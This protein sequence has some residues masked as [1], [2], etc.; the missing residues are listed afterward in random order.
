MRRTDIQ[1]SELRSR[2]AAGES[3]EKLA[4]AFGVTSSTVRLRMA[5]CGIVPTGNVIPPD[6]CEKVVAEY[7]AGVLQK[8]IV[9]KFGIGLNSIPKII[10][11]AGVPRRTPIRHRACEPEVAIERILAGGDPQ[12]VARELGVSRVTIYEWIKEAGLKKRWVRDE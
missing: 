2:Y 11:R 10:A 8:D 12:T 9:A 3:I 4:R 7:Q 1:A 5:E 6:I